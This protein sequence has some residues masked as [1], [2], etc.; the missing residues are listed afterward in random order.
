V[1]GTGQTPIGD[2][3]EDLVD[4]PEPAGVASALAA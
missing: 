3:E 4:V 1:A 2:L